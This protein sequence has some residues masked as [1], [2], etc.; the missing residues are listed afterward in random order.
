MDNRQHAILA[1]ERATGI[2][3][4]WIPIRQHALARGPLQRQKPGAIEHDTVCRL[5]HLDFL[6]I[7]KRHPTLK[8]TKTMNHQRY[9]TKRLLGR[10]FE[11]LLGF[12]LFSWTC[13]GQES[14][15]ER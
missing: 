11:G 12:A 9:C 10:V 7:G 2:K 3:M 5:R 8:S 4:R 1:Y 13:A 15:Q 6:K 14:T